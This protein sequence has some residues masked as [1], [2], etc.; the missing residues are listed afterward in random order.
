M[1]R[2][3]VARSGWPH[4]R[5]H[6]GSHPSGSGR[7]KS[8]SGRPTRSPPSS[9]STGDEQAEQRSRRTCFDVRVSESSVEWVIVTAAFGYITVAIMGAPESRRHVLQWHMLEESGA[10]DVSTHTLTAPQ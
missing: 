8:E 4:Q 9:A 10:S 7:A 1:G 5:W 6:C 2:S 3:G